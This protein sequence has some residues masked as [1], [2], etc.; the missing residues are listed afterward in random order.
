MDQGARRGAA[1]SSCV[2]PMAD[3]ARDARWGR[4]EESY[5]DDP[6][7]TGVMAAAFVKGLQGSDSK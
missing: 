3:L 6:V 7:L 5:G 4:T 2:H 1:E